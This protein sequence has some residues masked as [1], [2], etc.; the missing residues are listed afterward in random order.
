MGCQSQPNHGLLIGAIIHLLKLVKE[1]T[2]EA[3]EMGLTMVV[4][5]LWKIGA[6]LCTLMAASLQGHEAFYLDL[7]R[8]RKHLH[9]GWMGVIP[10]GIDKNT[11][12]L[13]EACTNLPHITICLL[14]KFKGER[15]IDHHL[16]TVANKTTSGLQPRWWLKKLTEVHQSEGKFDGP[17]FTLVD[18]LLGSSPDYNAMFRRYLQVVQEETDLIR[19]DHDVDALYSTFCMPWKMATTR[20]EQAGF[21]HQFVD[22]MNQWRPWEKAQVW[23]DQR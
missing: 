14:G 13:E 3:K 7:A 15:G 12:L 19:D 11:V 9:K 16:I 17:A 6:Y 22:Q 10:P 18:G 21:G 20:I 4:N 5:E 2:Q 8:L 23:A 1:D